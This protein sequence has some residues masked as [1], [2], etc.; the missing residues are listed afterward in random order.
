M[1]YLLWNKLRF[2]IAISHKIK[3]YK[4]SKH[5]VDIKYLNKLHIKHNGLITCEIWQL[6]YNAINACIVM[7][8]NYTVKI[9]WYL[10]RNFHQ[11][12]AIRI[13]N[14]ELE[15]TKVN[16]N[17]NF[18]LW[19]KAKYEIKCEYICWFFVCGWFSSF[20]CICFPMFFLLVYMY[21]D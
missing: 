12:K 8:L 1:S 21:S 18:C 2:V 9:K 7:I 4:G 17:F 10:L 5:K 16:L 15:T 14:Y 3:L 20:L 13:R 6:Q 19:V 11:K